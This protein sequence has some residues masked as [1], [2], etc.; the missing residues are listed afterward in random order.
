MVS[1]LWMAAA[2]FLMVG[3]ATQGTVPSAARAE[4]APTGKL[5]AGM[6]LGNALFTKKD[7]ATGELRGVSVDLMRELASR[8]GVDVDFVVFDTPGQVADAVDSQTWDVAILAIEPARAE[9]IHFTPPMT[10]IEATYVVPNDSRLRSVAEVDMPGIRVAAPAKAGYELYLS[11]TLGGATLVRT[12]SF[13]E[14]IDF[15]NQRKV[16]ALAGL[17]PAL[18]E[19]LPRT[20]NARLLDGN[21]MIVNHGL[22]TPRDRTA[23]A[24]Y[25]E[26]FVEEMNASG[27]VAR[28]IA[29]HQVRG[30]APVRR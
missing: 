26:A 15:F 7:A 3:C 4:L 27:F 24:E 17:R 29:R 9:R 25:L 20:P 2:G 13:A 30:L 14:S 1:S 6:N 28:S 21:F 19:A 16:D 5:R 12:K 22:C 8:L 11:R 23:G 10:E 18:L